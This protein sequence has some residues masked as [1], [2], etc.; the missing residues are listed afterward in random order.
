MKIEITRTKKTTIKLER[1]T[2]RKTKK[3]STE[4][5]PTP[6]NS[7]NITVTITQN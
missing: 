4:P 3:R 7:S 2:L 5:K 6:S 1:N